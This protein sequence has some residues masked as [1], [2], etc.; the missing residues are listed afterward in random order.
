MFDFCLKTLVK[1]EAPV[2]VLTTICPE[3]KYE[4]CLFD[5]DEN[6]EYSTGRPFWSEKIR[7]RE[8]AIRSH[9]KQVDELIDELGYGEIVILEWRCK[10]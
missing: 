5:A 2:V 9:L 4:M 3:W 8:D 1:S 7:V 6:G 10:A